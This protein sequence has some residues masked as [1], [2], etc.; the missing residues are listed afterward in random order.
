MHI[1]FL[2]HYFPPEVNAPA[3]RTFEN[4]R[5]WVRLGHRVTVVTCAPNHPKGRVYAGYRNRLFQRER[6][7]GIEVVR[8]WTW[9]AAN[10]GFLLRSLNY[11]SFMVSALA[12]LPRL[13]KADVVVTTSPQFFNGLAGYFVRL[14]RRIP[15]VFEVR[16][17][18]PESLIA[19]GAARNPML[20]R[21]LEGMERFAYRKADCIVPVTD[22]FRAH[23]I[24]RGTSADKITVIKNGADLERFKPAQGV[25]LRSELGLG[26]KF[27]AAYFG[28]HGMAHGL[29]TLLEAAALLH[30]NEEIQFLMVGDGAERESLERQRTERGLDNVLM[31]PQQ[32]K[33]RMPALWQ[34]A[35]VSLVLL[36]DTP[37]FRTVI[38]SKIFESLAMEKPVILGVEGESRQLIES[39]GAGVAITPGNAADLAAQVLQLSRSRERVR[40]MGVRGAA[41]VRE[42][43]DRAKL[44]R[45]YAQVLEQAVG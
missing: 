23:M 45:R 6:M 26:D 34:T 22:A 15:W 33:E 38:P 37:L 41:F 2:S 27:V 18:W 19:V 43:F 24:E 8:V 36:R 5:E 10:E 16:D 13:A 4:C 44:A 32:P 29:E 30:D 35:D 40:E 28:T 9:L 14:L 25:D 3:S 21:T 12:A 20:I 11:V 42:H 17:L 39:S 7:E 1:L 31:L